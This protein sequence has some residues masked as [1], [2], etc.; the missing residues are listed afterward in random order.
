MK[1]KYGYILVLVIM[2]ACLAVFAAC[3]TQTDVPTQEQYTLSYSVDGYIHTAQQVVG[4]QKIIL[5]KH[6]EKE[7]YIF[8]GWYWDEGTWSQLVTAEAFAD[9]PV[10]GNM[11]VYAKYTPIKYAILYTQKDMEHANPAE[12]TVEQ[13]VK[14]QPATKPYYHFLG[15][16]ADADYTVPVTE[17]ALGTL[18]DV[19][20]YAKFEPI[21]YTAIFMDGETVVAEV[22]Y[23]VETQS[24]AAPEVPEH[25]GY[26]GEWGKYKIVPGGF[27]VQASYSAISYK[28]TY[29]NVTVLE[30]N[31]PKGYDATQWPIA[32]LEATR[33]HYSFAGWYTE[34]ELINQITEIAPGTT[35]DLVLYAKWEPVQYAATFMD[36]ETVV[37]EVFYTIETESIT[38]PEIP[39]HAGYVGE[40]E[41]FKLTPGGITVNAVYTV[42]PYT[43]IYVGVLPEEH[44]NPEGYDATQWPIVLGEAVREHYQFVGWFTEPEYQ[45]LV[46]EIAPGMTGD[47]L[48]YA[49]WEPVQYLALFMDGDTVVE[50]LS[51]TIET[52]SLTPPTVPEHVGYMGKWEAF[53][54]TPGGII[55]NAVYTAVSYTLTYEGVLPEEH[56]NP[57]GYDATQWPIALGEA[58]REHYRFV[59]WFTEPEC[60]NLITEIAPGTTGDLVLYAK[61]EPVQY[62]ATFMDGET[63]VGEI[64]YTVETESITPPEVPAH[65]GYTGAWEAFELTPGGITVN[66]VYSIV[67]YTVT[68]ENTKD[69]AHSNPL[70]FTVEDGAK[71]LAALS[72]PGYV[73]GG[74]YLGE[75]RVAEIPAG[76]TGDLVL[77]ASWIPI[78][79][80][81]T[82]HYNPSQG[83]YADQSN[84]V[85]YTADDHF[86][87]IDLVCKVPG[88]VFDG[89]YTSKNAGEGEKVT[90]IAAGNVG[91]V[92]LY[93]HYRLIQY[94]ITY[95]GTEGVINTN[96]TAYTILTDTFT[97]YPVVKNGYVFDGW[98]TDPAFTQ[99][100]ELTVSKGS[101]GDIVLYAKWSLVTYTI[102]YVTQGGEM[103][104]NPTTYDITQTLAL[105]DPTLAGYV[106]KGWFTEAEGG[107]Q[108]IGILP[109]TMTGNLTL[110]A[111]WH[112]ISTVTFVTN[113]GTELEPVS[114]EQGAA[115]GVLITTKQHYELAGWYTDAELTHAYTAGVFPAHDITL[116]AKWKPASYHI[117]FVTDGVHTN[118]LTYTIEDTIVLQ[119][120]TKPGH[121]FVAWF[122]DEAFTSAP[123]TE[124]PAGTSGT[125]TL[126]ASFTV[127]ECTL[128]FD[129][130]G[131]TTVSSITQYYGSLLY[132]PEIPFK[133]G[134]SFVGWFADE[135]LT[136]PFIFYT[137]PETMTLYAKWEAVKYPIHYQL[138]GGMNALTNPTTYTIET[139]TFALA[140][141]EKP[142]YL[143]DGWYT[144][145]ACTESITAIVVGSYG[146][147]VL[148]AKWTPIVYNITYVVPQ[149]AAHDNVST[150]SAEAQVTS[151]RAAVLAGW[152]FAGW[153]KDAD[154]TIPVSHA[155]G[156][157]EFGDLVLYAK[158]VP[159][160]YQIWLGT[161]QTDVFTVAFD[162]N[163]GN[164]EVFVQTVTVEQGLIYP[165]IPTREGYLF[166]GWY[167]NAA[168]NG[169]AFDLSATVTTNVV[170]YAKWI[171]ADAFVQIGGSVNVTLDGVQ[172]QRFT[173][174]SLINTQITI[175][176]EGKLDTCGILYDAQ[177]NVLAEG[178]DI[179]ATNKNFQIVYSLK[180]G[181]AYT[182]AVY[183]FSNAVQGTVK[184]SVSG[185]TLVPAG[186]KVVPENLYLVNSGESFTLPVPAAKEQYKFLGWA[187]PN[188]V[189]YTDAQGNSL[190][191]WQ[192]DAS[193]VLH[194]VW[195]EMI[196]DL[197]FHTNGGAAL[198]SIKVP[199]GDMVDVSGIVPTKPGYVFR[200]WMLDGEAFNGCIMPDHSLELTAIWEKHI[201]TIYYNQSIAGVSSLGEINAD[202]FGA[203][204]TDNAGNSY[205]LEVTYSGTLAPGQ[206]ITVFISVKD[207]AINKEIILYDLPVYGMPT[208][209]V[210]VA[211]SAVS[212]I[213]GMNAETFGAS[214]VD[215]F[216]NPTEIRVS[217]DG[218]GGAGQLV[219]IKI[220]SIDPAGNV[221]EGYVDN[222]KAYGAPVIT[223]DES[224]TILK[225][226]DFNP[227]NWQVN[228]AAFSATAQDSFGEVLVVKVFVP[229][230]ELNQDATVTIRLQATD[231]M[232]NVAEVDVN[233]RIYAT[234]E[235]TDPTVT[236]IRVDDVLTAEL[237]GITA[238]NT[239]KEPLEVIL[240][241]TQGAQ[242]AG[243]VMTVKATA[244][245]AVG[246]VVSKEF[247]V[248]VYG[249]PVI[250]YDRNGLRADELEALLENPA[251]VLG[252]TAQD[253]FGNALQ[254]SVELIAGDF[255]AGSTVTFALTATDRVGNVALLKTVALGVYDASVI[256]LGFTAGATNIVS[257]NSRGEEFGAWATD[258]FGAACKITLETVD[259]QALVAGQVV[260]MCIVATDIQGNRRVSDPIE[261]IRVYD[262]PTLTFRQDSFLVAKNAD[263]KR[264]F[265]VTDSFGNS[266]AK[267]FV[268]EG[269]WEVGHT[270]QVTV[271]ATDDADNRLEQ[272]FELT[273]VE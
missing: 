246:N 149:G 35:G 182:V 40:W 57:A 227:I 23:T 10:S 255:V 190:T 164:G 262:M 30:H 90:E 94:T 266:L 143:F 51:Y 134:Y 168:C 250:H 71:A 144:D 210:Q 121:T 105:A 172:E 73:F 213:N 21:E 136:T 24:L 222:V 226:T 163:G 68:Y 215:S 198:E 50:G 158:F 41:A 48:L 12:F 191:A 18:G 156:E 11:T 89:W 200:G 264:L 185:N 138:V 166:A 79:Y 260:T 92:E 115:L 181:E 5:P 217:V 162:P 265:I 117:V 229:N 221:A 232:G 28:I 211:A 214:G 254:V 72:K 106:F 44:E 153:Y 104:E 13:Q 236:Q 14:L 27:T 34:P 130:C 216:G 53:E 192:N 251:E 17:I 52:E 58:V 268:I 2:M 177:G 237:F 167:D 49:K 111:R 3:D 9:K 15:W 119:P 207:A 36:G 81:I 32:L 155:L 206:F 101:T 141:P 148:Y 38:P 100:A 61:W 131:G 212:L 139:P 7:G 189:M 60:I 132:A 267:E 224:V 201:I 6:P 33:E 243:T 142:G 108:V 197:I 78:K 150:Y 154:Y 258:A 195:E 160:P 102:E 205:E 228:P 261:N 133:N 109:G 202:T 257:V 231:V 98:Y 161:D 118:P 219:R 39:L 170:L 4:S 70:T 252:A 245:D 239:Y 146:D 147:L 129:S 233:C 244:T 209:T 125:I 175:V 19:S 128:T 99:P 80:T 29:R 180:A 123:V 67:T 272:T 86:A 20:L 110:Y 145:P 93:A 120:A 178:D 135:E 184:L 97:I 241:I 127:N 56:D 113:G 140:V 76:S 270:V 31:N 159:N 65:A 203:Y 157:R 194:E 225:F 42:V 26:V 204:C 66:A 47:L 8:N 82:L 91:N 249:T 69:V 247:E 165:A 46:S 55:V 43:I 74:W 85:S 199:T 234:P 114:G 83:E 116:Y 238:N 269:E 248:E 235:M 64:L 169:A 256:E 1:Y 193:V 84:R 95:Q 62:T 45:N 96:P 137:M 253:S 240:T 263:L 75:E 107:Q 171:A 25:V 271:I 186:G 183:G 196:Y 151:L 259:G 59:G 176:T 103:P 218:E 187:D 54:L 87:L 208:L 273:I 126:F 152:T 122:M 230:R 173:I 188:G 16:Y 179:G 223:Y 112:Y 174:V 220:E 88:Y 77:R 37:A 124:I 22:P 242:V 63:V